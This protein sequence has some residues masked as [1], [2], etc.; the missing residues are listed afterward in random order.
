MGFQASV[1]LGEI[2]PGF[3][4]IVWVWPYVLTAIAAIALIGLA[5]LI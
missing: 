2:R 5:Y 4:W 3:K 1:A